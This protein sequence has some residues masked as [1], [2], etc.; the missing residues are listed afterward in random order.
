[1]KLFSKPLLAVF[2]I[3]FAV[4][5]LDYSQS[6]SPFTQWIRGIPDS[7]YRLH[8]GMDL[9][10]FATG[11]GLQALSNLYEPDY[12]TYAVEDL[13]NFNKSDLNALDQLAVGQCNYITD[14]WSDAT[15][16]LL[17]NS[18]WVMLLGKRSRIDF[19]KIAV[20]YAQ[21]YAMTP[22]VSQWL[23]PTINRK[24]P[25]FYSDREK[26]EIRLSNHAQTSLPSAHA[27]FAF[28]FATL[29]SLVFRSYY[30]DSPLQ[31]V[32]WPLSIGLATTTSVLRVASHVHFPT[33]VMAGAV[34]G[35]IMGLFVHAIHKNRDTE[36]KK[37]SFEPIM[38][39]SVG[40]QMSYRILKKR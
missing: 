7:P 30:P 39:K 25:Y 28:S 35:T 23:Q 3:I 40:L 19:A 18:M 27:N 14:K 34:T 32:V 36:E 38:G 26:Q 5:S 15:N 22:L 12:K 2:C 11:F 9:S 37:L 16:I 17:A 4:H 33:D 13:N 31:H 8:W 6:D 1:M 24:R 21:L 10:I 20:M 29:T